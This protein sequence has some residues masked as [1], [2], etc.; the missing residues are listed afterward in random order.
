MHGPRGGAAE[1]ADPCTQ[2]IPTYPIE[3]WLF[4]MC[5][6]LVKMKVIS[7]KQVPSV[8]PSK[9]K[10][11]VPVPGRVHI[12]DFEMFCPVASPAPSASSQPG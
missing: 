9:E 6:E 5:K 4:F 8:L 7:K 1:G 3:R 12:S 11:L 2:I 10:D